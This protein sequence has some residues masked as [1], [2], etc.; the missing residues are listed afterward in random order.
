MVNIVKYKDGEENA[1]MLVIEDRGDFLYVQNLHFHHVL[2]S[3][4]V[5][6]KESVENGLTYLGQTLMDNIEK[7]L[8]QRLLPLTSFLEDIRLDYSCISLQDL[9][10]IGE[11]L[12]VPVP[13]LLGA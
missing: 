11:Y 7:I 13:E 10:V 12:D 2:P 8:V 6:P 1:R 4:R 5:V 9:E 3:S